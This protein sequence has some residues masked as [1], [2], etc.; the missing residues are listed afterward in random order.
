MKDLRILYIED[1]KD[2]REELIDLL[3]GVEINDCRISIEGEELFETA[4]QRVCNEGFHLVILDLYKGRVGV[5]GEKSGLTTLDNVK[6]NFF[7]PIIFYSGN[8][9][10]VRD[11]KSQVVGIATKGD[12][13]IDELKDEI[14]R[15][16]LH[17]LPFINEKVHGFINSKIKDYF[18]GIIQE[19]NTKF[20]PDENDHS[21]GY[22]LLRNI[23]DSLSRDNIYQ[24]LD[25]NTIS[26]DK[27]HPMEFYVYPRDIG[28]EYENGDIIEHKESK[29]VYV[30]L[31]PSC[32]FVQVGKRK[33]KANMVLL[34]CTKLLKEESDYIEY[35]K[36]KNKVEKSE[37]D[38]KKENDY[39]GKLIQ[40]IKSSGNDRY[41]FLPRT[42]FIENR[43][44]DFQNKIM[45]AY[46]DL[47]LKF[48]RL[49][50]LDNPYAQA[51]T[52]RFVRYYNRIG[53][54]DIDENYVLD[55][56]NETIE[57]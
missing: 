27:V 43:V 13:G 22:L 34:A 24:I 29:D 3:S 38:E 23:S 45:V 41:F 20:K 8:T 30:I 9:A 11:L 50:K 37:I 31:T 40:L 32:D 17:N 7:V 51:M 35:L 6:K 12:G 48:R 33:R 2:N 44:I 55:R 4:A 5:D 46:D 21:L 52:T 49:T 26:P 25:D 16:T 39:K 28:A 54:P 56:I 1:D 18:W 53:F 47:N 10:V 19:N 57:I 42:P 14:T 15:L 36:Y